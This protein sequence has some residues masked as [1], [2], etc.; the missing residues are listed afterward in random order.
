[1]LTPSCFITVRLTSATVTFSVTWS[2]P[3]IFSRLTIWLTRRSW[4]GLSMATPP[5]ASPPAAVCEY[6]PVVASP[7]VTK[8]VARSD[9][10][11]ASSGVSTVPVSTT[12]SLSSSTVMSEFGMKRFR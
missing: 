3:M 12:L 8:I 2:S 1:M 10:R 9:A 11:L 6:W 5:A 7:P 4:S